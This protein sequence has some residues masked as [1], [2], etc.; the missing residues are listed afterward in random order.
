MIFYVLVTIEYL[1]RSAPTHGNAKGKK[2]AA[3]KNTVD[4]IAILSCSHVQFITAALAAHNLQNVYIP[5]PTNGP[6]F[7]IHWTGSRY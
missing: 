1:E 6:G 4:Q 5:G 3:S 2:H 7:K